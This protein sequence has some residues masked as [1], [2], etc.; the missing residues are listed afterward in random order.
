SSLAAAFAIDAIPWR[1]SRSG[2]M[3]AAAV[4][5]L[6]VVAYGS[7]ARPRAAMWHSASRHVAPV[8][9]GDI[10]AA[11]ATG[12]DDMRPRLTLDRVVSSGDTGTSRDD[13]LPRTVNEKPTEPADAIAW[14]LETG[15]EPRVARLGPNRYRFDV[16]SQAPAHLL[17]NQFAFPGW[18][19]RIDG[20]DIETLIDNRHGAIVVSVPEG[21]HEVEIAFGSTPM[22]DSAN[23]VSLYAFVALVAGS[24]YAGCADRRRPKPAA[25]NDQSRPGASKS[26]LP[27]AST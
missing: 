14:I 22:R 9:I 20:E 15:E 10:D 12:Y 17:F 11:S 2:W 1:A 13:Y 7:W 26:P 8:K 5:V 3:A 27:S 24:I 18:A 16:T 25:T 4:I 21:S 23:R 19:A 6:C